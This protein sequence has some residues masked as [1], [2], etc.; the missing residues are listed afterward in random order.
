[1]RR[2]DWSACSSSVSQSWRGTGAGHVGAAQVQQLKGAMEQEKA[3]IAA[4]MDHA[5]SDE[6]IESISPTDGAAEVLAGWREAGDRVALVTGRPPS[7]HA[8]SR[9]WLDEHGIEH[10]SLHHLDKWNR[11]DSDALVDKVAYVTKEGDEIC[12]VGYYK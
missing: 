2:R 8:A 3:E 6:I 4:F 7:T 5:H 10:E 9:R 11:P 1:M 12:A